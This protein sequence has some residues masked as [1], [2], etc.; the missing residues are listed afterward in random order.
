MKKSCSQLSL[1]ILT[2]FYNFTVDE[3][4]LQNESIFKI[5][6]KVRLCDLGQNLKMTKTSEFL[7]HS[8]RKH[9]EIMFAIDFDNF[10]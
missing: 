2:D 9:K 6:A 3:Q 8:S 4:K 5:S 10:D 1:V 7:L